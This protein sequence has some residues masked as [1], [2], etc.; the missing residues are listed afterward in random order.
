M[1]K[2]EPLYELERSVCTFASGSGAKGS[3]M[4]KI[5]SKELSRSQQ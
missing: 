3:F 4:M 2:A 1:R 5:A